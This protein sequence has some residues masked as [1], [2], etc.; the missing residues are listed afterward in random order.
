MRPNLF[1]LYNQNNSGLGCLLNLILI[2]LLLASVGLGWIVNGFLIF[3]CVLLL[4][5]LIAW[6]GLQWWLGRNL[7]NSTCPACGYAFTGFKETECLC[8]NCGTALKVEG[9]QFVTLT[10]P[11]TIDVQAIEIPNSDP[12]LPS[13]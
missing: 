13:E 6:V 10:P 8:P 4:I 5:P 11:G 7:I 1:S 9:K 3:V 2:G 12:Q